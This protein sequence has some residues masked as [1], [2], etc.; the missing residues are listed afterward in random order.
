MVAVARWQ[1]VDGELR[2]IVGGNGF[3]KG[4]LTTTTQ[5]L[6]AT[7]AAKLA[8]SA[9][10]P[11]QFAPLSRSIQYCL[12]GSVSSEMCSR[13]LCGGLTALCGAEVPLLAAK[14]YAAAKV[15]LHGP[16]T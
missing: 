9:T 1:L 7:A 11:A 16:F 4:R 12:A 3:A 8:S 6:L 13:D 10:R 2:K 5:P 14:M 15:R